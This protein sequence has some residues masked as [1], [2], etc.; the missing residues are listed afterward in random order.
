MEPLTP[1]QIAFVRRQVSRWLGIKFKWEGSNFGQSGQP[2]DRWKDIPQIGALIPDADHSALLWR[3]LEGKEPLPEPPP[4]K[5][6][7]PDYPD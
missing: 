3:L 6:A 5:H 7:Y 4:L 1:E 2:G